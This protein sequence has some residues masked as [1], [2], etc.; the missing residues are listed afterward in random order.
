MHK[1]S[2]CNLED[3]ELSSYDLFVC[4][5]CD[6]YVTSTRNLLTSHQ[7]NHV[8][9]RCTTQLQVVTKILCEK[10]KHIQKNHWNEGLTYLAHHSIPQADSR[11][12]L[13]IQMNF[14]LKAEILHTFHD[15]F[16]CCVEASKQPTRN[17][18]TDTDSTATWILVIVFEHLVL[19]L[20]WSYIAGWACA[21]IFAVAVQKMSLYGRKWCFDDFSKNPIVLW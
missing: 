1:P 13:I 2:F 20:D 15:V 3:S 10:V 8:Q 7:L 16:E 9:W 12:T 14:R 19:Q 11:S 5:Q 4:R 6:N 21:S 18:A 17:L